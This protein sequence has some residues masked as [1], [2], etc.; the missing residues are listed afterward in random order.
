ME[1]PLVRHQGRPFISGRDATA[2]AFVDRPTPERYSW[3]SLKVEGKDH[4]KEILMADPSWRSRRQWPTTKR[5]I[6][7]PRV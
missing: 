1:A 7:Q 5:A 3:S 2:D 6:Y 4:S